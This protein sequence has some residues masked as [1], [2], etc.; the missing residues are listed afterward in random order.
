MRAL[1]LLLLLPAGAVAAEEGSDEFG[2][3]ENLGVAV[4]LLGSISFMMGLFYLTNLRDK[5]LQHYSWYVISSTISIFCAVLLFQAVNGIVEMYML[6]GNEEEEGFELMVDMVHM[7]LWYTGL[8]LFLA[9]TAGAISK[10][11]PGDGTDVESLSSADLKAVKKHI[12]L[13]VK[14]W[15]VLL[16]HITGFAAIN[17]FAQLQQQFSQDKLFLTGMVPFAAWA[18]LFLLCSITHDIR[19][20]V[21]C[22]DDRETLGE[23]L[24]NEGTEE[25]ENDVV[26]LA[27]AFVVVQWLRLAISGGLPNTEGEEPA[28]QLSRH[29]PVEMAL[30]LGV[31]FGF[32]ALEALRVKYLRRSHS[33]LVPQFQNIVSMCFA[34]CLFFSSD[35]FVSHFFFA[36]DPKSMIKHVVLALF[37]TA[38]ALALIFILD[39]IADLPQTS[40]EVDRIV[41]SIVMALGIL[42]GFSWEK[43]F[44]VAVASIASTVHALPEAA[45]K[46]LLGLSLVTLVI[47]AWRLHILPTVLE[48]QE[49]DEEEEEEEDEA[50][51]AGDDAGAPNGAPP[52]PVATFGLPAPAA[53]K[54]ALGLGAPLLGT[55]EAQPTSRRERRRSSMVERI[56]QL[57]RGNKELTRDKAWL[58]SRNKDLECSMRK[59]VSELD[60][61]RGMVDLLERSPRSS[62]RSASRRAPQWPTP[63][64]QQQGAPCAF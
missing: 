48:F 63:A 18:I 1:S 49:E 8:Q 59:M 42:I 25:T 27:V 47:P 56:S 51:L 61:L 31:G 53:A 46:L 52:L 64:P 43:S 16:G 26:G 17:A 39:K 36:H 21:I 22:M 4:M 10:A 3:A 33:R 34:W 9:Y 30:L 15:A 44:D 11:S 54:P 32:T 23:Q 58:E 62:P 50:A 55:G 19:M 41:R 6:E 24:W 57:E 28:D 45:T 60:Q 14:C 2:G 38:C 40:G 12:N 7:M 5:D 20:G 35:W 29:A 37:V 13:Q